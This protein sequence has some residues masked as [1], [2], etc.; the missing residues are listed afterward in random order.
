VKILNL[1][2]RFQGIASGRIR[3]GDAC[4]VILDIVVSIVNNHSVY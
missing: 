3:N 2:K 1:V 4:L